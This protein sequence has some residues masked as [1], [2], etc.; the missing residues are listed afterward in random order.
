MSTGIEI[1]NTEKCKDSYC[2]QCL[3]SIFSVYTKSVLGK[4]KKFTRLMSHNTVSI[5]SILKIRH[6]LDR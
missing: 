4:P 1:A 5:A 6:G 3:P 2:I